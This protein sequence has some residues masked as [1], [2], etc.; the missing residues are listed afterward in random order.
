MNTATMALKVDQYTARVKWAE[1]RRAVRANPQ[2]NDEILMKGYREI[3]RGRKVIDLNAVI[4]AGG[5]DSGWRARLAI[6]RADEKRIHFY[7]DSW[8]P[9]FSSTP[10]WS[11]IGGKRARDRHFVLPHRTFDTP[12]LDTLRA[13]DARAQVPMIP[14]SIRPVH[15]IEGYHILWEANWEA[16]PVDPLLLKHIAGPLFAILAQWD[17]T[18][19]ERAV[20]AGALG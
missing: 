8:R 9:V 7:Y 16:P 17:L 18:D 2:A 13:V 19:L 11:A 1:Y 6:A 4:K 15:K 20:M 14:P 10:K 12:S 3:A 5:V